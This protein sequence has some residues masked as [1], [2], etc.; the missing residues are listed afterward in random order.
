MERFAEALQDPASGLTYPAL[1][2]QRK[3][4]IRDVEVLFSESMEQ[5]MLGNG[6]T[7]EAQYIRV[8]RNWR[9]ACDER[10]LSELQRCH[11]NYDLLNFLLDDLMPWHKECYDFSLLEVNRYAHVCTINYLVK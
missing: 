5:F 7:F 10:G 4:S 3:Q 1:T 9:R 11:F 6:Y 2:G 8:V